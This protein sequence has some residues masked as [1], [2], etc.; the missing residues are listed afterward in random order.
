MR[1]SLLFIFLILLGIFLGALGTYYALSLSGSNAQSDCL[2]KYPLTSQSLDC[3]TYNDSRNHLEALDQALETAATQYIKDKK[4]TRVGVW[5]RDLETKQSAGVD[6]NESFAPA[7]LLKVPLMIAYYK[8]S[9]INPAVL[10]TQLVYTK[11]PVLNSDSQNYRPATTLVEGQSYSVEDLISHMVTE[12]DN[13]AAALL[14]SHIDQQ[15]FNQTLLDLG[16]KVAKGSDTLDFVTAKTYGTIFRI[17]HNA[18]YLTRG[19]S[20]KALALMTQSNFKGM[21]DPLPSSVVVAHKFGEREVDDTDGTVQTRQL[22]DC[23]IVYKDPRPYSIC[24][25]TEGTDFNTLL[26]VIEEISKLTYDQI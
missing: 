21:S 24:I 4:V 12:S 23:G 3:D 5:V 22:H 17:L 6:E 9:E 10:Q 8:V 20:Q 16:I 11:S 7:S 18:S 15:I 13:D 25:M 14:L 1:K 2:T 19:D 26:S